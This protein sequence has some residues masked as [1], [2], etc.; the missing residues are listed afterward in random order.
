M[1]GDSVLRVIYFSDPGFWPY[2]G[3]NRNVLV[4][5]TWL[6]HNASETWPYCPASTL[7]HQWIFDAFFMVL[8]FNA[9]TKSKSMLSVLGFYLMCF[10]EYWWIVRMRAVQ[11]HNWDGVFIACETWSWIW[12]SAS[13]HKTPGRSSD[14]ICTKYQIMKVSQ[15][16][17]ILF[18]SAVTL[19]LNYLSTKHSFICTLG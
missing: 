2:L 6:S 13:E 7:T 5:T 12:Q 18:V 15:H 10:Q 3:K 14:S 19:K 8:S 11:W 17:K 1:F 4:L 16:N 9:K